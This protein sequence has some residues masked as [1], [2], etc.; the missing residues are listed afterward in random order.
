METFPLQKGDGK[1]KIEDLVKEVSKLT[2]EE[3]QEELAKLRAARRLRPEK[4][5]KKRR[6]KKQVEIID[7]D[8]I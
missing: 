2:D 5:V 6:S 3:L 8:I 1:M 7:M 4:T